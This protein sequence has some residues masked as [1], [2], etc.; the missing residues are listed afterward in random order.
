MIETLEANTVDAISIDRVA[1][2]PE[3][4][5]YWLIPL[6]RMVAPSPDT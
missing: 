4:A 3:F 1:M 6:I 5:M 2:M